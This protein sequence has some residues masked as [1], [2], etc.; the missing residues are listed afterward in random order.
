MDTYFA[1]PERLDGNLIHKDIDFATHNSIIQELL[2]TVGGMVAVL[3]E[4]RQIL[5]VNSALLCTLGLENPAE[6]L[7]L[8]PGEAL[9]CVFAKEGPNGCGTSQACTVCGAVISIVTSLSEN[10]PIERNCVLSIKRGEKTFDM[11]FRVRSS[12][13]VFQGKKVVL[14][15]LQDISAEH[16]LA[17]IERSF[18]HDINNDLYGISALCECFAME[19]ERDFKPFLSKIS[20][21]SQKLLYDFKLHRNF[22]QSK[23]DVIRPSWQ[24]ILIK[25][26]FR[27]LEDEFLNHPVARGKKFTVCIES[28]RLVFIT[29]ITALRRI[30]I[31]MLTNAFEASGIGSEVK[32]IF[33]SL[34]SGVRFSVWNEGEIPISVQKRIFQRN[35]STKADSGRGLGT[36]SMKFFGEEVLGGTLEFQSSAEKG[37]T[38]SITLPEINL[39]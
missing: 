2:K 23:S 11:F 20:F 28:P 1:S 15:F 16:K 33:Q 18:F 35:F 14:L 34:D 4:H 38:F 21:F 36:F 37:T 6:I 8:R 13:I 24:K 7:G 19:N 17:N 27:E 29:D 26:I 5:A 31:N 12:P 32:V 22:L 10:K 9:Q 25:D 30:L 39:E 3:N